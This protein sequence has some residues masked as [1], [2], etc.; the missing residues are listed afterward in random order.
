MT[1]DA[2]SAARL[3]HSKGQSVMILIECHIATD[4]L[5][6]CLGSTQPIQCISRVRD[7]VEINDELSMAMC[8]WNYNQ[9]I[10]GKTD[11]HGQRQTLSNSRS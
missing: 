9:N 6:Q 4:A 11:E 3:K 1:I 5:F 10:L 7:G 8:V 2:K